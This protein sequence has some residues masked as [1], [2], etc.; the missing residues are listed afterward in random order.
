M[1]YRIMSP[2]PLGGDHIEKSWWPRIRKKFP[3]YEK[4]WSHLIVHLTN[5]PE[6]I[7][8]RIDLSEEWEK[9]AEQHYSIYLHLAAILDRTDNFKNTILA[10][11][12]VYSHLATSID[13]FESLLVTIKQIINGKKDF[14]TCKLEDDR[15]FLD[16]MEK[17]FK[18]K[19][20]EDYLKRVKKTRR[21]VAFNPFQCEIKDLFKEVTGDKNEGLWKEYRSFRDEIRSQRNIFIHEF[22]RAKIIFNDGRVFIPKDLS[23]LKKY[24]KWSDTKKL[25]KTPEKI[26]KEFVDIFK[27]S[28][29]HINKILSLFNKI[30]GNI[31]KAQGK[32]LSK[33][34]PKVKWQQEQ[35]SREKY[36]NKSL[37]DDSTTTASSSLLTN[38]DDVSK[39]FEED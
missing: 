32:N 30:W 38:A 22:A 6:N 25:E 28:T 1:S 12:E 14:N 21:Y 27:I 10:F 23:T 16:Y 31:W 37:F 8:L 19:E 39:L 35:K 20:R 29:K 24:S 9:F 7:E 2:Y 13:V 26:N 3:N 4:I 5:R 34:L 18:S 11:E 33:I 36:N 15:A 17:W